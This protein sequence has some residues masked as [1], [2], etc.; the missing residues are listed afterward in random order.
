MLA[1]VVSLVGLGVMLAGALVLLRGSLQRQLDEHLRERVDDTIEQLLEQGSEVVVDAVPIPFGGDD[2]FAVVWDD[3][4]LVTRNEPVDDDHLAELE[5]RVGELVTIALPEVTDLDGTDRM[6]V[7]VDAVDVAIVW[8]DGTVSAAGDGI[9]FVAVG[10]SLD[11]V[12]Q[13]LRQVA[14]VGVA[15]VVV[16]TVS[17]T[18]L[19][20]F[21][22]RRALAPVDRLRLD[23]EA[24]TA[25]ELDRRLQEPGRDDELG[26]LA[27]TLNG[28]LDRLDRAQATQRR[29]VSDASHELRNPIAAVAAG[30]EVGLRTP[31]RTDWPTTA[32]TSLRE[33]ERVRRLVDDLLVLARS[34]EG[35]LPLHLELVDLDDVVLAQ[36]SA[37][38]STTEIT[39]DTSSVSPAAVSG[40]SLRLAQ[41]VTNLLANAARHA[42]TRISVSV[43]ARGP[44]AWVCVDDD[45]PGVPAAERDAV[46]ERFVRLDESRERDRGGSGLGLT[47]CREIVRAHGGEIGVADSPIGGARFWFRLPIAAG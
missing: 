18:W 17:A 2:T 13:V 46:F 24:I 22:T 35:T 23:A 42:H 9:S 40:D 14:A 47:I 15:A 30:L 33:I 6:R 29:F 26:R 8:D 4:G 7:A 32:R 12:G 10:A 25:S 28:M 41:I 19:V 5:A 34:D 11:S 16:L 3:A 31:D 1:A 44:S 27:I 43:T 45:G 36:A 21:V 39:I 38:R 37:A 20:S